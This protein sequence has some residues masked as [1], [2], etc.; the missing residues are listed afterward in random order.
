MRPC[1]SDEGAALVAALCRVRLITEEIILYFVLEELCLVWD[2]SFVMKHHVLCQL[3]GWGR[4]CARVSPL[5]AVPSG[6]HA[7]ITSLSDRSGAARDLLAHLLALGG[8]FL[9]TECL[10]SRDPRDPSPKLV[11]KDCQDPTANEGN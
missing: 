4:A 3:S 8:S 5:P 9:S 2:V 10:T 1:S 11:R 6:D 7:P